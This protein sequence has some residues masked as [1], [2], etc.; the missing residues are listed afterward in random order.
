M[1]VLPMIGHQPLYVVSKTDE[2]DYAP[3]LVVLD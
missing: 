3:E 1:W 2:A